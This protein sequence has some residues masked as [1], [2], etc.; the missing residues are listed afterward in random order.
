MTWRPTAFV[1]GDTGISLPP[2]G[3]MLSDEELSE[4]LES[5]LLTQFT[6]A[7]L[8]TFQSVYC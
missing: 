2:D 8:P 7:R 1:L 5:I 3:L 6:Y 4:E